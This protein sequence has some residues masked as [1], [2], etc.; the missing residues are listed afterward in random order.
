MSDKRRE[1]LTESFYNLLSI[2]TGLHYQEVHRLAD[3]LANL[4]ELYD[5]F[6]AREPSR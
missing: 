6:P 5:A 4:V 3:E 1:D 2:R